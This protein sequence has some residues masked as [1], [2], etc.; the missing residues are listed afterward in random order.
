M[1]N[2]FGPDVPRR[3]AFMIGR[4]DAAFDQEVFLESALDGF[5]ELE[6][7]A[8]AR[9]IAGALGVALPADRVV[10]RPSGLTS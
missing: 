10:C 8:R 6:L 5:E 1:K 3:I 2:H 9:H 7:T 4:I